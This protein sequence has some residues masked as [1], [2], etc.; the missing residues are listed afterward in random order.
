MCDH[1]GGHEGSHESGALLPH[2]D[3]E[4]AA[5]HPPA[6]KPHNWGRWGDADE[7]G[8]ANFITPDLLVAAAGLIRTG[9]VFSLALTLQKE[10]LP[11]APARVVPTHLMSMDAGDFAAG[12]AIPGGFRTA[13]DYLGMY[14]Q[15]GTHIDGLGHVWYGDALYNGFPA[16]SVRSSGAER[17]GMEKLVHL[18][19]RGVLLDIAAHRGVPYLA[20]GAAIGAG[21]LQDCAARQGVAVRAGDIVLIRTGWLETYRDDAPDAFWSANPGI[22]VEAAEWLGATGVAG[23]GVDNFAVEV[24]P[25]ETGHIGPVHMRLIRDFGCYLMELVKLDA[26]AAARV[27]EFFFVAAPLP[28]RGGTGSPINP[29]AFT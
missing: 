12:Y 1:E 23:I 26:L 29:L 7:R 11:V 10:G 22:G 5:S 2:P 17:L 3:A 16:N 20:G 19:G 25:S 14:T 18:A 9:R 13:D 27:H 21:E 15:T 28:I 4:A 24:H 8:A 6:G